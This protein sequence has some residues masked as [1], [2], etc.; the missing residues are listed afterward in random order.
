MLA[1]NSLRKAS[2]NLQLLIFLSPLHTAK[3]NVSLGEKRQQ[4]F[5]V[6]S[7]CGVPSAEAS[8]PRTSYKGGGGENT[9]KGPVLTQLT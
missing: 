2:N 4:Q 8:I 5:G 6:E 7:L 9:K 1:W 3:K